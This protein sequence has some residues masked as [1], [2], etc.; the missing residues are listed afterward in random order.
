MIPASADGRLLLASTSGHG[1]VAQMSEVVAETRKGRNVVNL[2]PKAALAIVRPIGAQDDSV[3]VVG[4]NRK[5]V[6]FPLAEVPVM[7]RGQG[8]MLQRYRD[9]G[10]SDAVSFVFA[11]GL[12]WALGG[13]TGRT[14]TETDLAPWPLAPG[15]A[16]R[17]PRSA[18]RRVG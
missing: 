13:E 8:V 16:G 7:A 6:V 15:P 4:E 1:F 3:A 2:K 14:P 17:R 10:L 18:A 5:L 9:G 12:S 11:D